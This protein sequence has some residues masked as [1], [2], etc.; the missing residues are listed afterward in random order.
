MFRP[1]YHSNSHSFPPRP[2]NQSGLFFHNH[3]DIDLN[4]TQKMHPSK[5]VKATL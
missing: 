1:P 2:G 4:I 5:M 3:Y